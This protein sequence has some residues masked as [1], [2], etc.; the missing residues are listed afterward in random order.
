[1][2]IIAGVFIALDSKKNKM[3][4]DTMNQYMGYLKDMI[5]MS[6]FDS[7]KKGNMKL[8][9]E[10]LH[11]IGAYEQVNEFSLISSSDGKVHYSSDKTKVGKKENIAQLSKKKLTVMHNDEETIYYYPVQTTKYCLRCHRDWQEGVINSYYKANLNSSAIASIR[12]MSLFNDILLGVAAIIATIM[13]IF[14]MQ[15][16]I[17]S[18]L[19]KANEVLEDLC[20]GEGD[21]TIN[22]PI[23]RKDEI[24]TLR[25]K[26]NLF[27]NHL[28]EM[29][30]QL[31]E[32]ISEVDE[33]ISS[34]QSSITGINQSVQDNVSHIMSIS[35]SSEQVSTT[36][37]DNINHLV[38]LNSNVISKKENIS[39]SLRN[40]M[41]ITGMI[42]QMTDSVDKLSETVYNLETRSNDINNI[43][44]LITEIADQT[45]LLAL[46]AAIEA[47]RAGEAGRGFAV[48]A[49][50]IRKL[51]ER[52]TSATNDIKSIVSDNSQIITG[53]V[54]EIDN[55]K[56][57]AEN[58]NQGITDLQSFTREV[59]DTM[60]DISHNISTL[61]EQLTESISALELTLGSIEN[62]NSN[63]T[64]TGEIS[65]GIAETSRMLEDKSHNMKAI[66]DK[67][68]T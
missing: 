21:L 45:N 33:E 17:F 12:S 68:K 23:T 5:F 54:S 49:D 67:F 20:S 11:E 19:D 65:K 52:T 56:A 59:D 16:L 44:N 24:G 31:K 61:N 35:S 57:H 25:M 60:T 1:M 15:R 3:S 29:M 30:Q 6:T 51:A 8:F 48:V 36:L 13:V 26:I 37:N 42:N 63:M 7:L 47:A 2:I 39:E 22:L 62:V 43:T 55:N 64:E 66:A 27:I 50:E 38:E 53:I 18:R 34:I 10:M 41:T 28:R 9:E 40:V 32:R 4:E 46:N 14:V 58:M